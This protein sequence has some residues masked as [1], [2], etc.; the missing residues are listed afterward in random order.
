[1]M[2]AIL[3]AF[4]AFVGWGSGDVFGGV[5]SRKIG[6]YSSSFW[7]YF[8]S[9]LISSLLIPIFWSSLSSI[10]PQMWVL[11]ISLNLIGPIP[12]VALYEGIRVGNASL[13]GT[14]AAAFAALTVVLSVI[15]LKDRLS[16]FQTV[17]IV[18]IFIGLLLSSLKLKSLN[19]RSIFADKGVPY[20]LVAMILW[21]IYYTFIR[22]P[23]REVGW[24]WPSY[25][26][27]LGIPILLAYMWIKKIKL[28]KPQDSKMFFFSFFNALLL[29]GAIF[30][31]N[32]AIM[33][34]QTSIIAPIAGSYPVLY[35][36]L[37]KFVFK[38]QL[39]KQQFL[40]IL[41]TLLGIVTL[42]FSSA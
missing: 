29:T 23:V 12:V 5:I 4:I 26:A 22:I 8:F 6:G 7:L 18:I 15:F 39:T 37:A 10:S 24:F 33:T 36:I 32:F 35:V 1:M 16:F 28:E 13:V 2:L 42:S 25:F 27:I 30:S 34:G 3:F 14:I 38:E 9:L 41:V 20:G 11:I 21:G 19:I 40:G 17:S 31:Y